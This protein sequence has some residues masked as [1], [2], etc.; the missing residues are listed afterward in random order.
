MVHGGMGGLPKP[1]S[2]IDAMLIRKIRC[3]RS[4]CD[5]VAVTCKD[6]LGVELLHRPL[7][8][9]DVSSIAV[10]VHDGGVAAHRVR[11]TLLENGCA[12]AETIQLCYRP[13]GK[14]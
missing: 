7:T 10:A 3:G 11:Q 14:T 2:M 4:R 13:V 1:Q 6:G 5:P 9:A 8:R 12:S